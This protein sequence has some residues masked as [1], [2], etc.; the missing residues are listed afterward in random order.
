MR[1]S[2]LLY[3]CL[4]VLQ[5]VGYAGGYTS[6]GGHGM[7]SGEFGLSAENTLEF[8]IITTEGEFLKTSP[9]ENKELY[10]AVSGGVSVLSLK[11]L[12]LHS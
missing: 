9:R 5:T 4:T 7:L 8:E 1:L 3:T 2:F 12:S 10:R 11:P 6:G